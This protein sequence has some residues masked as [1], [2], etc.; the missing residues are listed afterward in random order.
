M[1]TR[2]TLPLA[3]F[4]SASTDVTLGETEASSALSVYPV[5]VADV[6]TSS[7][8]YLAFSRPLI[9]LELFLETVNS[10]ASAALT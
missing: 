4:R 3:V 10:V 2:V 1:F 9:A 6:V 7:T 8:V 5:I